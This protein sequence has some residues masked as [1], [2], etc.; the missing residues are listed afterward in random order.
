MPT[1]RSLVAGLTVA[2][3]AISCTDKGP[4][5][6]NNADNPVSAAKP[7]KQ[8]LNFPASQVMPAP[9]V[10][11][12]IVYTLTNI[13]VTRFAHTA[14]GGLTVDGIFTFTNPATGATRTEAFSNA[15]A[16]LTSSGAPTAP[17]CQILN[18]DLGPLHL[19]LLGLVVDLDEVHLDITAQS[20]PGNLLGNLLC[21]L[22]HLLDQNP[23][24]AAITNLINQINALLAAL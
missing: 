11:D 12:G 7:V 24:A 23:L 1:A 15:P 8:A 5:A 19:N 21:A 10:D 13:Q 2:L 18:L 6:P 9:A 3:A 22:T 20:G 14:A 4:T 17:T 16:T